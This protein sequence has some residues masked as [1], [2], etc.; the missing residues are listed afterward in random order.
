M[1]HALAA[2]I[3]ALTAQLRRRLRDE[4][5]PHGMTP[6]EQAVVIRLGYDGPQTLTGLAQAEGM[7]S[8]SMGAT[9]ATLKARGLVVGTP[10]PTDGRQTLLDLTEACRDLIKAHRAARDDWLSQAIATRFTPEEQTAVAT[11]V[12]LLKRLLD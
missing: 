1:T 4:S 10:D 11:G 9:V 8:Q 3:R 7:R 12:D 2:D 5:P 6:S